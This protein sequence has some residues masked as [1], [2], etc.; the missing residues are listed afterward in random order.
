MSGDG[1]SDA[2]GAVGRWVHS[3]MSRTTGLFSGKALGRLRIAIEFLLV[4]GFVGYGWLQRE[5]LAVL[6]ASLTPTGILQCII[7]YSLCHLLAVAAAT[8]MLIL[9][10]QDLPYR[11]VLGIHLRCLPA[12]YLP[13]G[14][15]HTV[16]RGTELVRCGIPG[17]DVTQI[18][19]IEQGLSVWWSGAIGCALAAI[20]F[21]AGI[22]F[23]FLLM[24]LVW[25]SLPALMVCVTRQSER[26]TLLRMACLDIRLGLIFVA[27]WGFLAA[28]FVT[29]LASGGV[30]ADSKLQLSASYLLSWMIGALVVFAPQG[31]G[32]FEL[33]MGRAVA[34]LQEPMAGLVWFL[35]SYRLVVL[36]SDLLVWGAWAAFR[37]ALS[38]R[39]GSD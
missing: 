26:F 36:F 34:G 9:Q 3:V 15:W 23:Y 37:R 16:G 6:L 29:Y 4:T 2:A 17:R 22:R 14:I 21:D 18:L 20:A 28:A 24:L 27:G 30:A 39:D 1:D 33:V 32:V 10:G 11:T 13:G 5:A 19:L 12:K 7:L 25:I 8:R 31:M 38:S 35:G